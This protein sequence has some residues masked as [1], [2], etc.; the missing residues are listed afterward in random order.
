MQ[1]KFSESFKA[2]IPPSE[3]DAFFQIPDKLS[4][5]IGVGSNFQE[6]CQRYVSVLKQGFG[7][8]LYLVIA[9][10]LSHSNKQ[11]IEHAKSKLPPNIMFD[12]LENEHLLDLVTNP[13]SQTCSMQLVSNESFSN[14]EHVEKIVA[15]VSAKE[16]K[17]LYKFIR[18][19]ILFSLNPRNKL[20]K[21]KTSR[22][23]AQT[24]RSEPTRLWHY[25]NGVNAICDDFS[26]DKKHN[27]L[28]M[29]NLKIVNGCQTVTTIAEYADPIDDDATL[30]IRLSKATDPVFYRNISKYTNTQNTMKASDLESGNRL[31]LDLEK[32]FKQY[33]GK[34]FWERQA[35]S[36][37]YA[38]DK[39][40]KKSLRVIPNVAAAQLKMA[41]VLELPHKCINVGQPSIFSPN[42]YVNNSQNGPTLFTAIYDKAK[43]E[44]FIL[45][46]IFWYSLARLAKNTDKSTSLGMLLSLKIGKYYIISMI[47]KILRSF[48][49][50]DRLVEKIIHSVDSDQGILDQIETCLVPLVEFTASDLESILS[51][52]TKKLPDYVKEDLKKQLGQEI[53]P[54]LYAQRYKYM[55]SQKHKPDLFIQDLEKLFE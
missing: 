42:Y 7:V 49:D 41:F 34:F 11:V 16:L 33:R 45:P 24:L 4:N 36:S 21:N 54:Q 6:R 9:G 53:F 29:W 47:G 17:R 30:L 25:N 35:G 12:L 39:Y 52:N 22:G 20:K 46:N 2:S 55:I 43:P 28:T 32:K 19:S 23:I 31:L 14:D 37:E 8:K 1:A 38:H 26:Y 10:S 48:N 51:D 5:N 27:R 13:K 40:P 3:L 44:D 50:N 15:T 18:P